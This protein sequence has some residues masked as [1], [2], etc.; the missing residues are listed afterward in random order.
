MIMQTNITNKINNN[1]Y[2]NIVEKTKSSLIRKSF[3]CLAMKVIINNIKNKNNW[4]RKIKLNT[5]KV[6]L[7]RNSTIKTVKINIENKQFDKKQ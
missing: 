1:F 3:H 2:K 6:A 5:L 7:E 4:H